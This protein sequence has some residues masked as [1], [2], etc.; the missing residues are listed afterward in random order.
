MLE[1]SPVRVEVSYKTV[2]FTTA[3]LIGLWLIIQL[4]EIIIFL[5]LSAIVLS[6]LLKPVEWLTAK[7]VPRALATLLVYIIVIGLLSATIAIIVPPLVAQT[8]DFISGIPRIVSTVNDF[9]VFNKIPTEDFA[10]VLTQ[11]VQSFA[12]NVIDISKAILSSIILLLT[13][14]VFTFYLILE[15]KNIV[16]VISSPFSGRQEKKVVSIISKVEKGLGSWIRGQ[17]ALSVVVGVFT[18]IG[19]IILNVPYALPLALISGMFE[20]IPIIGPLIAAIPGVLVGLSIS[21]VLGLATIAMYVVVQQLE[22]HL[23]VPMVMSKVVGLQPPAVILALLI[24]AK[25]SGV[26]GAFFAIPIIVVVKI[27]IKE[28]LME[29]QKLEDG[30]IEE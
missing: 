3:F 5:F 11:Q 10:R 24:G 15:W 23:I 29:D 6:A 25:L 17:L 26:G 12:G 19:L 1:K 9:L 18:Y 16:R 20:I 2:V 21:P 27:L 4:K 14:L 8:S 30:L 28:L 22:N 13:L 7:R